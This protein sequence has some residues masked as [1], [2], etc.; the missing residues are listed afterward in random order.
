MKRQEL[1]IDSVSQ[2]QF[3]MECI[4]NIPDAVFWLDEANSIVYVNKAACNELGYSRN[5]LIGMNINDID[6]SDGNVEVIGE[7]PGESP[8]D[9]MFRLLTQHRHKNGSLIP[10]EV[11]GTFQQ[12][13]QLGFS[14]ARDITERREA[15]KRI[16]ADFLELEQK[17]LELQK[18]NNYIAARR[19]QSDYQASHDALTGLSNRLLLMKALS[20][21]DSTQDRRR[22]FA[23][24]FIDLDNF[25]AVNDTLG[26]AVGDNLLNEVG[27]RL[28][29]IMRKTDELY[30]FGGDEFVTILDDIMFDEEIQLCISRIIDSFGDDFHIN[31]NSVS[32]TCSIGA[33]IYPDDAQQPD[34]LMMCADN[35]MYK[36]KTDGKNRAVF[37]N[38]M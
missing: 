13:C 20:E 3:A 23:V 9:N 17:N 18:L 11:S 2:L 30:R 14:I 31:Q 27:K 5:E 6:G 12:S 19:E 26:H 25:K 1:F 35:A 29:S 21:L 8:G 7:S 24:L 32:V 28:K 4:E 38:S 34:E 16:E 36:A 15:E 22:R 37:Y 10:V 33:A